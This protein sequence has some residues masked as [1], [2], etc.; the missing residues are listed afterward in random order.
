MARGCDGPQ[1]EP[2]VVHAR[3]RHPC[4]IRDEIRYREHR[5]YAE[6]FPH[7]GTDPSWLAREPEAPE[8]CALCLAAKRRKD[9]SWQVPFYVLC[10]QVVRRYGGPEEGGWWQDWTSILEVRKVWTFHGGLKAAR[11]LRA[12]YPIGRYGRGSVLG[13]GDTYVR[14]YYDESGFPTE[15]TERMAYA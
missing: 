5:R 12:R 7:A 10:Y 11:E 13:R 3:R 8:P 9:A 4:P 2:L 6:A 15:T 1:H 14:T